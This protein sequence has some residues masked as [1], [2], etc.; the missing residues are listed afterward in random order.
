MGVGD[1]NGD[2]LPDVACGAKGGEKF[3][4]GEWFAWWEQPKDGSLPW[5]KHLLSD[6]QPGASNILPADFDGDGKIDYFATRGHGLGAL[7]FRGPSFEAIE[8]DSTIARLG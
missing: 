5:K 4:G 8:V 3:P 1:V 2:G 6:R 7:W